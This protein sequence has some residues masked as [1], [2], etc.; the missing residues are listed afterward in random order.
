MKHT[1]NCRN[2]EGLKQINKFHGF[3]GHLDEE[4]RVPNVKAVAIA[5]SIGTFFNNN[6][7]DQAL[8][9]I[10]RHGHKNTKKAGDIYVVVLVVWFGDG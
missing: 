3:L 7:I 2:K 8:R 9:K 1:M 10:V 5:R 4:T 6:R